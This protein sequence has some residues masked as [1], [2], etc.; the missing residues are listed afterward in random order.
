MSYVTTIRG[1]NY[2][3]I[4]IVA[5]QITEDEFFYFCQENTNLRIER[6]ADK[7]IIIMEPTGNESGYYKMEVSSEICNWAKAEKTGIAFSPSTGFTM[8]TGHQNFI[9]HLKPNF[10]N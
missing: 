4:T 5:D 2:P 10:I 8:P 1:L 6:D 7:K 9:F 3:K